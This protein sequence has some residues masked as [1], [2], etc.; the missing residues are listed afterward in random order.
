[1]FSK[2]ATLFRQ[3]YLV[4]TLFLFVIPL[5]F[6]VILA[7]GE[8]FIPTWVY[9]HL[10]PWQTDS[11]VPWNVLAADGLFEFLPWRKVVMESIANGLIPVVN[12]YA[13][14]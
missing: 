13:A 6:F 7:R 3:R 11:K 1:M 2:F 14:V 12:P 5:K 9:Q 8:T 4:V 10:T